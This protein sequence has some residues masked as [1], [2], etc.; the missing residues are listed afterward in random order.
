VTIVAVA[1]QILSDQTGIVYAPPESP[2][3]QFDAPQSEAQEAA[4]MAVANYAEAQTKGITPIPP[5]GVNVY[6]DGGSIATGHWEP[7]G[8]LSEPA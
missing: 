5:A 2:Q 4:E 8:P 7:A 6:P 3:T 1:K